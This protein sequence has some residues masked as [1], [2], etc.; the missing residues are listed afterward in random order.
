ME[1][2]SINKGNRM[3][4]NYG[5]FIAAGLLII[6]AVYLFSSS[7]M[8]KMTTDFAQA[9]A[10]ENLYEDA[11]EMANSNDSVAEML[12]EIKPIDKMT[13]LNGD[14]QFSEDN[15]TVSSTIKV[16]GAKGKAKNGFTRH[17]GK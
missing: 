1:E 5:W 17:S 12:G 6:F 9:Y 2:N 4:R 13:L 3:R 14:V 7:G 11:I 15:Q 16:E 8:G 10:D